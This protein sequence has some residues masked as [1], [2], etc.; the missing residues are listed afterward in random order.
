MNAIP[1]GSHN[2]IYHSRSTVTR[3]NNELWNAVS[4]LHAWEGWQFST[5]PQHDASGLPSGI[6]SNI[7]VLSNSCTASSRV[8]DRLV[9]DS[10]SKRSQCS[11][12]CAVRSSE[13]E[14][15][16]SGLLRK[17]AAK[18]RQLSLDSVA[19]ATKSLSADSDTFG[20]E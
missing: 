6:S 13:V 8:Q 20:P 3:H 9:A 2:P 15:C 18:A 7:P 16:P 1:D 17:K 11:S 12:S 4:A 5:N 14:P 19:T 10:L